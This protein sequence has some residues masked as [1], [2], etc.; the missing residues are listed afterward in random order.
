M[1]FS[2]GE[3]PRG[4][5]CIFLRPTMCWPPRCHWMHRPASARRTE[6]LGRTSHEFVD[7]QMARLGVQVEAV[8][9]AGRR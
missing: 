6:G 7:I 5:C 4:E 9:A 3:G 8:V 2:G 1:H